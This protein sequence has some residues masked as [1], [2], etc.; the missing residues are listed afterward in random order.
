MLS[1]HV[2]GKMFI[3][4]LD[5]SVDLALIREVFLDEEYAHP[6]LLHATVIFDVGAN[7]GLTSLYLHAVY[8][9][10]VIHAF[11][12]NPDAF[13][14]L[15]ANIRDVPNI[16]PHEAALS[17]TDGLVP[18]YVP[19]SSLASSLLR[20]ADG[21]ETRVIS[22]R[23]QRLRTVVS[24]LGI[25]SVDLLKFDIEGGE[26]ALFAAA[27]DRRTASAIIG[28]VHADLKPEGAA[29]F[30]ELCREFGGR[31]LRQIAPHRHI[32]FGIRETHV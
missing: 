28:E 21:G 17:D 4:S 16:I 6:P 2:K 20:R 22:V 11:E 14:K 23:S 30:L 26:Y 3:V 25:A 24:G 32:Y 15:R 7:A 31:Y 18:L 8:P 13:A 12:P 5:S 9:H 29:D 10:A 19:A 27:D 1:L